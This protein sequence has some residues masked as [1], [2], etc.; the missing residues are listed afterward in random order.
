VA[1]VEVAGLRKVYRGGL[2]RRERR[3]LDGLDL[4]VAPGDIHGFLGP[5]G[6]GKTTTL[7]I[8]LGLVTPDAGEVRLL[9]RSVPSELAAA[10]PEIG[11]VVEAPRFFPSFSGRRNLDLLARVAGLERARVDE[12]LEI[13]GL[14]D[15]ARDR[16]KG[17]S[18][19]MRQ[20]LGIAQALM[21]RPRLLLLDEPTNGLDPA[22]IREVRRLMAHLASTGVT[23]LLSSHLLSEVQQ[24][25]TSVTIVAQGRAVRTGT[26]DAVLAGGSAARV[27][28]KVTDPAA[29]TAVLAEAGLAT[30]QQDS[31]LMVTGAPPSDVNR[32]LGERGIWADEL[33][34]DHADLEDVVLSLTQAT[35]APAQ[36]PQEIPPA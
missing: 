17:Y 11:S 12:A 18:L 19:G 28:L 7:R 23:V 8:L 15:R 24:I 22:G 14:T 32:M 34:P 31:W 9:G 33:G 6:S 29:A 3:A 4:V 27:R 5:N 1:A 36:A 20:R 26:V 25:C 13:V 35:Q 21:K 10:V 30:A 16:V 2:R